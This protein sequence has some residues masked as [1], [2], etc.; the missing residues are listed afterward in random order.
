MLMKIVKNSF[1]LIELLVVVAILAILM[2]LFTPA[3]RKAMYQAKYAKCTVGVK[4]ITMGLLTYADD[5][6]D[7]YPKNG[8]V[9]NGLLAIKNGSVYNIVTSMKPYYGGDLD[10]FSCPLLAKPV[11]TDT[12]SYNLY[13]QTKGSHS[14]ASIGGLG[15]RM[16]QYDVNGNMLA[17]SNSWSAAK[18]WYYQPL[19][20]IMA[21]VGDSWR[22]ASQDTY[23][24]LLLADFMQ[25]Y[26][27]HPG[28]NRSTNHPG[29]TNIYSEGT[30]RW[31][32]Q[33]GSNLYPETS[34]NCAGQD[35]SVKKFTILDGR[36]PNWTDGFTGGPGNSLLPDFYL[37][38]E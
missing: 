10:V 22:H 2:S 13:F 33:S 30:S 15:P 16:V 19:G 35:G 31:Q 28:Y 26:G 9:R 18:T 8:S 32:T 23:Y 17:N 11:D 27:G 25:H 12:S 21:R 1:T 7:F 38:S 24:S 3:L 5:N 4:T 6:N 36:D 37:E 29:F 20:G 14:G 34:M